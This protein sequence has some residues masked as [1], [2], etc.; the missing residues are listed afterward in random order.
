M[1]HPRNPSAIVRRKIANQRQLES[2][3]RMLNPDFRIRS[4]QLERLTI[5]QQLQLV[6]SSDVLL[7]MHGAGLSHA[8]FLPDHAGLIELVPLGLGRGNRHFE[9]IARWRRLHYE[10]WVSQAVDDDS[11]MN[12]YTTY[13]PVDII[14]RLLK[15]LVYNMC[16]AR[17][18]RRNQGAGGQI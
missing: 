18:R 8:M 4:V 17:Q 9:A 6:T 1:T 14:D 3:L 13:I 5:R 7:G 16:H 11:A 10:R 15:R 12:N 2:S